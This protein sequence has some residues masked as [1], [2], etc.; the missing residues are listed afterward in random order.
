MARGANEY[1][2]SGGEPYLGFA[3]A[4][5]RSLK[6]LR[7]D[8]NVPSLTKTYKVGGST[9]K[10]K[11]TEFG[12]NIWVF[13][14][15]IGAFIANLY[16]RKLSP[17]TV[18]TFTDS[19]DPARL[20]FTKSA[21]ENFN[22]GTYT[23]GKPTVQGSTTRTPAGTIHLTNGVSTAF[24]TSGASYTKLGVFVHNYTVGGEAR[25]ELLQLGTNGKFY[26][27]VDSVR[28]AL[29]DSG[30]SPG[31]Y[32]TFTMSD[33]GRTFLVYATDGTAFRATVDMALATPVVWTAIVDDQYG[34]RREV[35]NQTGGNILGGG[36]S[37]PG[38]VYNHIYATQNDETTVSASFPLSR[39]VSAG[40]ESRTIWAD[41]ASTTSIVR[42]LHRFPADGFFEPGVT[43]FGNGSGSDV[44]RSSV[45]LRMPDGFA[46]S[47][48]LSD[49]SFGSSGSWSHEEPGGV[50]ATTGAITLPYFSQSS[51]LNILY[52]DPTL[53]LVMFEYYGTRTENT[54]TGQVGNNFG[55]A[56]IGYSYETT[57][58]YELGVI[59]RGTSTVIDSS[60]SVIDSGTSSVAVYS[61]SNLTPGSNALSDTTTSV[62]DSSPYFAIPAAARKSYA[63]GHFAGSTTRY[64][65]TAKDANTWLVSRTAQNQTTG[66]YDQFRLYRGRGQTFEN[67][68]QAYLQHLSDS[69]PPIGGQDQAVI[70][71]AQAQI[72]SLN[73]ILNDPVQLQSLADVI[74]GGNVPALVAIIN[75]LIAQQQAIIDA[76]LAKPPATPDPD[77]ALILTNPELFEIRAENLT[78]S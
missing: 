23:D 28:T 11:A 68:T 41:Y 57:S 58:H 15:G 30:H 31:A 64:Y 1:V 20:P 77:A 4:R 52:A 69:I 46:R 71:A 60:T 33:D 72:D 34:T 18:K 10:V 27:L 21:W 22:V 61:G 25:T 2:Q 9:I 63:F 43:E 70:D 5:L 53:G 38:W 49:E 8:L 74:T 3:R 29:T 56:L 62:T 78:Y 6:A 7:E 54:P 36:G 44:S 48:V 17:S 39:A 12:D 51:I 59:A 40:G 50:Y 13:F 73:G 65:I 37:G 47:F 16:A 67:A 14:A 75:F 45:T 76:E 26:K 66:E 35:I 55:S 32:D 24:G 42:D 19:S